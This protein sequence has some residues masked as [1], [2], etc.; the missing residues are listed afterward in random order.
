MANAATITTHGA[1]LPVSILPPGHDTER[2]NWLRLRSMTAEQSL[3][4]F[5][6]GARRAR[7]AHEKAM[8]QQLLAFSDPAARAA[9]ITAFDERVRAAEKLAM[10]PSRSRRD[11]TLKKNTIG[12]AW[13]KHPSPRLDVIQAY[14]EADEEALM[15]RLA[16]EA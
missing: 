9:V 6:R 3:M 1:S 13:L 11:L 4:H 7:M 14:M 16:E 2:A 12:A 15:D 5:M 10:V 8:R